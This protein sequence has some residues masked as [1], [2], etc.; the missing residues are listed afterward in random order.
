[1]KSLQENTDHL[2]KSQ[3]DRIDAKQRD[4]WMRAAA[5]GLQGSEWSGSGFTPG[6]CCGLERIAR[7]PE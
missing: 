7:I 5:Y 4:R 1:M 6:V 2:E 3:G